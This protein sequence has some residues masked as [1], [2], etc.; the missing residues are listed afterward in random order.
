MEQLIAALLGFIPGVVLAAAAIVDNRRKAKEAE[1]AAKTAAETAV[2][3]DQQRALQERNELIRL[4]KEQLVEPLSS[5][6]DA[7]RT[8][9]TA[10]EQRIALLEETTRS[11]LVFIY[12]QHDV[13]R[14]HGLEHEIDQADIPAGLHLPG[15]TS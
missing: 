15:G 8:K 5:Q 10:A 4:I 1:T 7:T 6:L 9:L 12:L 13:I 2:D 14:R 3:A 11:H